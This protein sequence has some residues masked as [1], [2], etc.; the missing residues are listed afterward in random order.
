MID[1]SAEPPEAEESAADTPQDAASTP[2]PA[3]PA[4]PT[5]EARLNWVNDCSGVERAPAATAALPLPLPPRC[6][7]CVTPSV[8]CTS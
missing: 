4:T 1:E 5:R 6:A 7:C 2:A 8:S 3:A